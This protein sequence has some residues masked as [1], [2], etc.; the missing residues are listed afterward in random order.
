MKSQQTFT[1]SNSTRETL[2]VDVVLMS[3]FL[4]LNKSYIIFESLLLTL[5]RKIF[6]WIAS[7]DYETKSIYIDFF[8]VKYRYKLHY[9]LK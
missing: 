2:K 4:P 8:A 3:L 1:C 9:Y 6:I 5:N 7:S